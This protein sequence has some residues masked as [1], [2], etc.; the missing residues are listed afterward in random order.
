MN[1]IDLEVLSRAEVIAMALAGGGGAGREAPFMYGED[2]RKVSQEKGES[3]EWEEENQVS[4]MSSPQGSNASKKSSKNLKGF[5]R[6]NKRGHHW[7]RSF[8]NVQ[9]ER[10]GVK[11]KGGRLGK[12]RTALE[13]TEN[14]SLRWREA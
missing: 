12:R 5:I 9:M 10:K 13:P 11:L 14:R 8:G 2:G 4:L 7:A 3:T 1:T 6:F